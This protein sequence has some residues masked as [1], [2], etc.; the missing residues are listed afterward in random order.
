MVGGGGGGL[1]D[2]IALVSQ[3]SAVILAVTPSP[4]AHVR[5]EVAGLILPFPED[6]NIYTIVRRTQT[7]LI[8]TWKKRGCKDS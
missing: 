3:H 7:R 4:C 5:R 8:E 6:P 1:V 2:I